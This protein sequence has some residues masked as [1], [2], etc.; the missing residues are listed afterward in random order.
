MTIPDAEALTVAH[1]LGDDLVTA[2]AGDRIG[3]ELP[4]SF[5]DGQRIRVQRA[6]GGPVDDDT[7]RL[8]RALVQLETFGATKADAFDLTV[9][10]LDSLQRMTRATF[11]GAVVTATQRVTGPRWAPDPPTDTPRYI[12]DVI[13]YAHTV[14]G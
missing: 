10:V 7:E 5:P 6:G 8:D 2:L 14:G 3:A 1:L 9:V 13:L 4:S 11:P 12:T